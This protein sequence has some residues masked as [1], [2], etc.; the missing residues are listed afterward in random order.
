[1][2]EDDQ[3]SPEKVVPVRFLNPTQIVFYAVFSLP[4]NNNINNFMSSR[5]IGIHLAIWRMHINPHYF[6]H[7]NA[8][9]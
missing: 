7:S 6:N 1:M 8:C 3:N 5:R 9:I 4:F 2:F